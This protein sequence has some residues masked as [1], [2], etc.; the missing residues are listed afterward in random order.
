[1]SG[2]TLQTIRHS[3]LSAP[4]FLDKYI[5]LIIFTWMLEHPV[6]KTYKLA[7]VFDLAFSDILSLLDRTHSGISLLL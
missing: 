7:G 2:H 3:P 6:F 1:M 4:Y 5:N